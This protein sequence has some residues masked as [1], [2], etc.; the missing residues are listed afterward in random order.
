MDVADDDEKNKNRGRGE[1]LIRLLCCYSLIVI[2]VV[3]VGHLK[4]PHPQRPQFPLLEN[5]TERTDSRR[6]N[7]HYLLKR[8]V[9]V[10][11]NR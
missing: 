1:H 4:S 10:S 9:V 7:G 5:D 11:K 3:V 6:T 2:D 8:R